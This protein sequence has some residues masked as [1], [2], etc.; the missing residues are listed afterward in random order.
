[1]STRRNAR[2]SAVTRFFQPLFERLEQRNLLASLNAQYNVQLQTHEVG[3]VLIFDHLSLLITP[4]VAYTDADLDGHADEDP[5]FVR[6]PDDSFALSLGAGDEFGL[7]AR[8]NRTNDIAVH[9]PDQLH[10]LTKPA[11]FADS[12]EWVNALISRLHG[13]A[14]NLDYDLFPEITPGEG[15]NSNSFIAGLLAATGTVVDAPSTIFDGGDYP[16]FATPVPAAN[17]GTGAANRIDLTFVIDTTGSMFDDIAA[18][19]A[20]AAEIIAQVHESFRVDGEIDARISVVDYRDFPTSP[21]GDPGD[22]PANDVQDFTGSEVTA[23]SGIQALELGRGGDFPE[24]VLS[25]LMHAIDSTSLG[26][27]RGEG[28]SKFII[29]M[30]DAPPHDP[31]PFTGYTISSVIDA[32][33]NEGATPI[34]AP[35]LS[36]GESTASSVR[37]LPIVIGGDSS[38]LAAFQALA[39]GTGGTLFQASTAAEVVE[40]VLAA[41]G[42]AGGGGEGAID[43][44]DAPETYG[45]LLADDGPTHGEGTLFLGAGVDYEEDGLPSADALGDD[46]DGAGDDDEDGVTMASALLAGYGAKIEFVASESGYLDAWIDFNQDGDF[47]DEGEQIASSSEVS[48]DLNTL[49][50]NVPFDAEEGTT[51]ARFRLSSTGEL[52]PTGAAADGEVEDYAIE[53]VT[54]APG[55]NMIIEDPLHPGDSLL[56]ITGTTG[57]DIITVTSVPAIPILHRPARTMIR[58]RT[59]ETIPTDD[60]DRL[61]VNVFESGDYVLL[62]PRLTKPAT[63]FAGTGNDYVTGQKGPDELYGGT[64]QDFLFGR[65][66]NDF[67]FGEEGNDF[68]YGENDNDVLDGGSGD[69]YLYGGSGRD[70]LVGGTGVDRLFGLAGDDILI[71]GTWTHEHDRETILTI[72]AIWNSSQSFTARIAGLDSLLDAST[73]PTE[74]T[75]DQIWSGVGRDWILDYALRDRLYD[76]NRSVNLGDKKN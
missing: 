36:G 43:T 27:W 3:G 42:V 64:G 4:Q 7:V 56:V 26:K 62:D 47:T 66:G 44:G 5:L 61:L 49:I 40:A 41:I 30:G 14:D 45:T 70:I 2:R 18:V 55:S 31:E 63:V 19:Q 20:S 75:V 33:N 24:S 8:F 13:Y 72:A 51:Y 37:I 38:A 11:A 74:N 71:G 76:F 10:T 1:M 25:G 68:L 50:I 21:Y 28:V 48:S 39:D 22:Y 16:G 34:V 69:D 15:F 32:A 60:F 17:F 23:N 59:F 52:E 29:V 67:I 54:A 57:R 9:T 65:S 53:L 73:V 12:R 58:N 46:G 35:L 6:R